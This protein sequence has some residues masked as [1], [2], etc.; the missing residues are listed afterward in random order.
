MHS[1][2]EI[3]V[4]SVVLQL[5]LLAFLAKAITKVPVPLVLLVLSR[6]MLLEGTLGSF[7]GTADSSMR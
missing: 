7:R 6:N 3:L 4:L 1:L 5:F 2:V